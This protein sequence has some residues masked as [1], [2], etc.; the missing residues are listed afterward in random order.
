MKLE[1]LYKKLGKKFNRYFNWACHFNGEIQRFTWDP[2][3]GLKNK[4]R[5]EI[6]VKLIS[7][8][9]DLKTFI[10]TLKN[11]LINIEN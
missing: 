8:K 5:Q 3:L 11:K 7:N 2:Y 6:I 10:N 9:E 4:N 1:R